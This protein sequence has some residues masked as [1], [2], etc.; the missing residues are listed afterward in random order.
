MKVINGLI[1][2]GKLGEGSMETLPCFQNVSVNINCKT[3]GSVLKRSSPIFKELGY[4]SHCH[5][6]GKISVFQV[7]KAHK[8]VSWGIRYEQAAGFSGLDPQPKP[9]QIN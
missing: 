1:K 5:C 9:L 6:K 4:S 3:E 2:A 8:E 7:F